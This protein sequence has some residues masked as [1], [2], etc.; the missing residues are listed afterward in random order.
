M[1]VY[2]QISSRQCAELLAQYDIGEMQ[3]LSGIA[4]GVENSNFA[5]TTEKERYILT[6]YESRVRAD[7]LP[8]FMAL[9]THLAD[10]GIACP[11][12]IRR[13]DG[14]HISRVAKRD[15]AIISFL[16]GVSV[17]T[18]SPAHCRAVGVG[19][20]QL[21]IAGATFTQQR[22][23][24]LSLNG[25][26]QLYADMAARAAHLMPQLT[27]EAA[28]ALDQLAANWPHDLPRGTIHADLFPD[29]VFFDGAALSGMIDFY[30]ACTDFLA[31]DLAITLNAWC[32]ETDNGFNITKAR[33]LLA[34][35]QSRRA[36]TPAER[37]ALPILA[38][39]AAMRFLLTR[40]H[41]ALAEKTAALM[42]P[43]P[44]QEYL[45]KLRFHRNVAGVQDYGLEIE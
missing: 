20:A 16:E 36:L 19:L 28:A 30:F 14:A 17:K 21:H 41:D 37:E 11:R 31:Y 10:G 33:A 24:D 43:K 8:Y 44:P 42:R 1:A 34:G 26:Q 12:P 39:G 2:T 40:L 32:F 27:E 3:S 13:R 15:A 35:Y 38:M 22:A 6:L 5:L 25:W 29:N 45:Q 4:A 18:P 23:N 7:D 9:M